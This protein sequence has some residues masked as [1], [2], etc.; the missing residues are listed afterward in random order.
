MKKNKRGPFMK[1]REL[2]KGAVR[3]AVGTDVRTA[4]VT[5]P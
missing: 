3:L 2:C 4:S 5:A 1:H